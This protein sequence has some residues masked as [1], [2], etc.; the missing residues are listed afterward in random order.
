M[1]NSKAESDTMLA[2]KF[3]IRELVDRWIITSDSGFWDEFL[4]TWHADGFMGATWFQANAADF[5]RKRREGFEAGVSIIHANLGHMSDI[6]GDRAIAQTKMNIS[7][8]AT[9]HDILVDVTATGRFYDF[10]AKQ[11]GSWG[12]V[13]RQGLY[14]KDRMDPVDQTEDLKLDKDLL[15]QFPEGYRHLAYLQTHV[16]FD[17]KKSGLPL[18]KGPEV[19]KLYAEGAAWLDGAPSPG[20]LDM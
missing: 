4:A 16:G 13:R 6:V 19:E 11:D 9:V 7:Q 8:R 5:T 10:L 20:K 1:G 2:D 15:N 18:M 17:V 3:A 14:E 12:I